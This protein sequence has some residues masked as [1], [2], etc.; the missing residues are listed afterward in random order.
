MSILGVLRL[1]EDKAE[2]KSIRHELREE[3]RR[4]DYGYVPESDWTDEERAW[5]ESGC[6][7]EHYNHYEDDEALFDDDGV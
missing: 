1:A 2:E 7:P 4:V 6:P 5:V 3:R